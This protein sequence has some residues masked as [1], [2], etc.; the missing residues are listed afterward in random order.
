MEKEYII[1]FYKDNVKIELYKSDYIASYIIRGC[2]DEFGYEMHITYDDV[3]KVSGMLDCISE[4]IAED[5]S[6][7]RQ[8]KINGR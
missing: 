4:K 8:E 1:S 5:I 6:E 3:K 2:D 7:L